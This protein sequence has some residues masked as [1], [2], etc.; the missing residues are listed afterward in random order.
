FG[1]AIRFATEIYEAY[2]GVFRLCSIY[3]NRLA[4]S[5]D[6]SQKFASMSWVKHILSGG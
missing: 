4:P 2:N 1:P 3:S 5:R 6:I